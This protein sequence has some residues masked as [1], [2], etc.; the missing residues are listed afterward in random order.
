VSAFGKMKTF[1]IVLIEVF[2]IPTESL[3]CSMWETFVTLGSFYR[4]S[5]KLLNSIETDKKNIYISGKNLK[6]LVLNIWEWEE[7]KDMTL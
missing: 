2:Y 3:Y 7:N 5:C 6:L 4:F 1:E